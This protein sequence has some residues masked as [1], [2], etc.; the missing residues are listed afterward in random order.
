MVFNTDGPDESYLEPSLRI[1]PLM[2]RG[3]SS[4]CFGSKYSKGNA[5]G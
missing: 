5:L 2:M 1:L 3:N 4:S